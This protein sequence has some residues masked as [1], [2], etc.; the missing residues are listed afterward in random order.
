MSQSDIWKS[1][2]GVM[3][4][5][6]L[7]PYLRCKEMSVETRIRIIASVFSSFFTVLSRF[8]QISVQFL[9]N[10]CAIHYYAHRLGGRSG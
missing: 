9:Q 8:R 10:A 7:N 6:V 3:K 2:I 5:I 4:L 1:S